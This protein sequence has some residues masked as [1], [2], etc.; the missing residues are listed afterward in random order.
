MPTIAGTISDIHLV[1]VYLAFDEDEI[2][3]RLKVRIC[4]RQAVDF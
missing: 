4:V 2:S 1:S 3:K